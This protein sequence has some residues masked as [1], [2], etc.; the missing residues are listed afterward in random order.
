MEMS[1]PHAVALWDRLQP[2]FAKLRRRNVSLVLALVAGVALVGSFRR[3][4]AN[5]ISTE[6]VVALMLGTVIACALVAAWLASPPNWLA[7]GMHGIGRGTVRS[8]GAIGRATSWLGPSRS[9]LAR[10]G[11]IVAI[12]ALVL[13]VGWI[14]WRAVAALPLLVTSGAPALEGRAVA[15]SGDTL[16]VAGTTLSLA[17][18]ETPIDGQTCGGQDTRPWR[19]DAAAKVSLAKVLRGGPVSCRLSGE[20]AGR[21]TATCYQG[22]TDIAAELVRNGDV[23]A[24][25]G[26]FSSYGS[27]ES[28]AQ[29]VKAGIWAGTA[30]RPSE[31]R[32]QKWEEAKQAAPEG[33]PIKGNVS[34]GR[35]VY[36]LPWAQDYERVK[37]TSRRGERWFCSEDEALAAGWKPSGQS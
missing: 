13:G 24:E 19:C 25:T 27:L 18:V 28:E 10:G 23:F 14:A 21:K 34:R 36:V 12:G 2:L 29:A 31:Y 4:A 16:R 5:G 11:A 17:G 3:M 6:I 26:F 1:A 7:A 15:V 22:D 20:N 33:C 32:A 8:A 37:I 35:R 9:V 30:E